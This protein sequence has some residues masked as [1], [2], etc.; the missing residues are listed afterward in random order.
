MNENESYRRIYELAW[1]LMGEL[2][3][4]HNRSHGHIGR[5]VFCGSVGSYSPTS[6]GLR[7][8]QGHDDGC[9]WKQLYGLLNHHESKRF[10]YKKERETDG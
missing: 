7:Y 4:V 3:S 9:I 1:G 2:D 10:E 6:I 5:C 8:F